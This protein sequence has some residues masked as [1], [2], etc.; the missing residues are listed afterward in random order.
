MRCH[1]GVYK[2]VRYIEWIYSHVTSQRHIQSDATLLRGIQGGVMLQRHIQSD[3]TLLRG[4]QGGVML[5]KHIQSDVTLLR[6]I[7]SSAMIWE[8][9]TTWRMTGSCF[10]TYCYCKLF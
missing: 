9:K 2:V 8:Y 7:Q 3:A 5:Q 1:E 4:I 10:V 6:G